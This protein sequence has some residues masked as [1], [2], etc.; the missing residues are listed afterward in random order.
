M[1]RSKNSQLNIVFGFGNQVLKLVLNFISR[2]IFISTLGANYLGLSGLFTNI[3]SVLSLAE[4]GIG[5]A[6]MFSL[7]KPIAEKDNKKIKALMNLYKGAYRI[8]GILI[9]LIGLLLIPFLKFI[10]KFDTNIN[11]NYTFVYILF[12]INSV[13]SYLFFAYRSVIIEASQQMY[14]ITKVDNYISCIITI[15]QI[16]SLLSLKNYYIYL[17]IP[18]LLG[19]IKNFIIS[20]E[21]GTIFPIIN[22]KNNEKLTKEERKN[23]F[24]NIYALSITKISSV[25]YSSTDNIVISASLGTILVGFYSNYLLITATITSF[26]GIIFNSLRASLGDLN[27]VENSERKFVVY[28]RILFL[29]FWIYGFCAICIKEL[30]NPFI[31]LWIGKEYL[32][33]NFTVGLIVLMFLITGLNHTNTIFKDSCG[34]FWQTRYRTLATAIVN[35]V[36]SIILVNYIGIKGIFIGTIV[37]YVTT[38]YLIDPKIVYDNIFKKRCKDFYIWLVKSFSIIVITWLFTNS[39]CGFISILSWKSL[40]FKLIICIIIPNLFFILLFNKTDEFKYYL[41]IINNTLG[42]IKGR[43]V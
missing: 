34:L 31:G 9:L 42:K 21:A 6:I 14:K 13:I 22:E 28:K 33:D 23:I 11:I 27:A 8:I 20:F 3:L 38:I 1:S 32:F 26:I 36:T 43:K 29:N 19:I 4:L 16:G 7:Y 25:V 24:K 12:L 37:S 2:T 41:Q 10:V 15:L 17:L 30:I 18:I 5:S 35:L 39:I 40:A